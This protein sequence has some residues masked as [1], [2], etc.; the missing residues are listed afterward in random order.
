MLGIFYLAFLI[1]N[2]SFARLQSRR[3]V[4]IW[5]NSYSLGTKSE[6]AQAT[7]CALEWVSPVPKTSQLAPTYRLNGQFR[8]NCNGLLSTFAGIITRVKE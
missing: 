6:Q 8:L 2:H 5:A 3:A 1:Q 4:K 7:L